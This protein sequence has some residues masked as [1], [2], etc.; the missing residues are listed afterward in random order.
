MITERELLEEIE[1][2]Q[3]DPV[4]YTSIGK[5]ADLYTVQDHLFERVQPDPYPRQAEKVIR[6]SGDSEFLRTVDGMDSEKVFAVMD[7]LMGVLE[8]SNP[9]LYDGVMRKL[10]D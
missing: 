8:V 10:D 3:R 1:K 6:S 7:E 4:T 9:R 2:C 5:L